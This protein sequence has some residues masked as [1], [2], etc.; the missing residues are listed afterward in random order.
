MR[1]NNR[2]LMAVGTLLLLP[3]MGSAHTGASDMG[4]WHSLSHHMGSPDHLLLL[5]VVGATVAYLLVKAD[6]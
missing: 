3:S 6:P 1:L 4:I 2:I 5:T